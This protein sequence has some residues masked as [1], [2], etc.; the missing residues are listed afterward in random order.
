MSKSIQLASAALLAL[1]LC[2]PVTALAQEEGVEYEVQIDPN[3]S[4][5]IP[6][7]APAP[8]GEKPAWATF[9]DH[10]SAKADDITQPN[11]TAEEI[12]AWGGGAVSE[13]L[14]FQP[15]DFSEQIRVKQER[16]VKEG[17]KEYAKFLR[18][19]NILEPAQAGQYLITCITESAPIVVGS[20]EEDG[21][22]AWT[23][24][25]PVTVSVAEGEVDKETGEQKT[26]M[27][28][29]FHLTVKLTRVRVDDASS[30]ATEEDP[31]SGIAIKGWQVT[32]R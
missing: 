22:W 14:S 5:D 2:A 17:W 31:D 6:E 10:Y 3:L 29:R 15:S 19:A 27:T 24:Q 26:L 28:R 4:L 32:E 30:I 20:G 8:Q 23:F 11:R 21:A 7:A 12:V 9:T 13:A 25:V 1:A 18:N 16:F